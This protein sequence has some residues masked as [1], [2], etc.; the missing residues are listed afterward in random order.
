MIIT[1]TNQP[2]WE[3]S[4]KEPKKSNKKGEKTQK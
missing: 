2:L 1:K 4:N 3:S